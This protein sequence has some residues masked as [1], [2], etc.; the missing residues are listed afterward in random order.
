MTTENRSDRWKR[1]WSVSRRA[2]A[3]ALVGVLA[4]LLSAAFA[5]F[6]AD[7]PSGRLPPTG[8]GID[9]SDF[10]QQIDAV[11]TR[12]EDVAR[13]VDSLADVSEDDS[14]ADVPEVAAVA[15]QLDRLDQAFSGLSGRLT[16]LEDA[17][18]ADPGKALQVPLLSN[19]VVDLE[20]RTE[21]AIVAQRESVDRLYDILKFSIVTLAGGVLS[22][23]ITTVFRARREEPSRR[24]S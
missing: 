13:Q 5:L 23:A 1:F 12:L 16:R 17:I 4:S 7:E 22:I 18:L 9:P 3:A 20:E 8:P 15:A 24:A 14:L 19:Q 2:T 11:E 6:G 10:Q 21:A